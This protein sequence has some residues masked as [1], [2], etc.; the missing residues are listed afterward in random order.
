MMRKFLSGTESSSQCTW[1]FSKMHIGR[2]KNLIS[3]LRSDSD[4]F[5]KEVGRKEYC[6]LRTFK[7]FEDS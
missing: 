4:R 5:P 3:C 6:D 7:S 2:P 1:R